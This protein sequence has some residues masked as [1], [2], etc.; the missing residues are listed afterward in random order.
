MFPDP[1][2]EWLP[3]PSIMDG[4]TPPPYVFDRGS[5]YGR[6]HLVVL[7]GPPGRRAYG[8]AID[9]IVYGSFDEMMYSTS[10]H[11]GR[12]GDY[13]GGVYIKQAR[14]SLL[15]EELTRLQPAY[16]LLN[17][18]RMPRHFLFVGGDYCFETL[19]FEEPVIRVFASEDDAF[20]WGPDRNAP[21]PWETPRPTSP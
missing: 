7:D 12:T 9:C 4:M 13:G 21:P 18:N 15:M 5:L 6:L 1:T 14:R 2:V 10:R 8:V 20:A 3:Y 19:G 16:G 17:A 11:G